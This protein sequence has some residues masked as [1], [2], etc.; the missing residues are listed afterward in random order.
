MKFTI[1][2]K[3]KHIRL[4]IVS[5]IFGILFSM[6][7]I[8]VSI[9]WGRA[10]TFN[11]VM[12][13]FGLFWIIITINVKKI[14]NLF[15]KFP[16]II[17][18]FF[19]VVLLSFLLS[20][21]IVECI[22]IYNMRTTAAADADYVIVLGC[23]VDGSIPSIPL[24]RRVNTAVNYLKANQNTNVVISGGQGPGENIT[25]A[26]AMKRILVQ[27]GINEN[28][29]FEENTSKSTMENFMFSDK[30]YNL[31]DK[32]I[33]IVSTDYHMFRAISTAKKLNYKNIKSLPSRSQ[34]SVLPVY[35]LREYAAVVYYKIFRKI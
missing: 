35:L 25:E 7:F 26:A 5:I 1:L 33:V 11:I 34:L 13:F 17:K 31:K 4:N 19:K 15:G 9:N 24:L 8:I 22:I 30:L 3:L 12:V 28:R 10:D 14:F 32:N 20:F 2:K 27:N 21:V 23:Q 16:R 18:I 29:I 6:Y